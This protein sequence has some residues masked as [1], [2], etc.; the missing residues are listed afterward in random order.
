MA[1]Q[2]HRSWL[3]RKFENA[4]QRGFMRAYHQVR[5]DPGRF[6]MQLRSAHGLPI[7]GYDGV[8]QLDLRLLDRVA[9]ET[10]HS[11]MNL[12]ALQGAGFGLGGVLTLVPDMSLMAAITLRTIQKLSLIYGFEFN[13]DKEIAELWVATASAAGV[14]IG[15]ELI[16]KE[17]VNKFVPRVIQRIAVSASA[18]V[19]EKW[20]ARVIPVISSVIGAGLNYYFI[21]A[22]GER[23][24]KHFRGKHL[25]MRQRNYQPPTT[26]SGDAV[27]A[28]GAAASLPPSPAALT[29]S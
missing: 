25:E 12:A 26:I 20:A 2:A 8:F 19:V 27:S 1:D 4:I 21:R 18:E 16:E 7:S 17:L 10:I 6:L 14:D 15:R 13:S 5:V 23:A 28:R 11:G 29:R 24:K 9:E 3:M 22:W